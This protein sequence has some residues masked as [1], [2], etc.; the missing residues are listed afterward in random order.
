MIRVLCVEDETELRDTL[1][2]VLEEEGYEVM[3]AANGSEAIQLMAAFRP[4]VIVTD[5]LMPVMNGIEMI[6][7]LRAGGL[8]LARTPVIV[9]SAHAAAT[10]IDTALA[11]GACRYLTKPV[12]FDVLLAAIIDFGAAPDAEATAVC[13]CSF[14][15]PSSPITSGE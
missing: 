13:G 1:L 2:E 12:D 8:P 11:M 14:R 6:R 3:S 7:A 9:V 10:E 4:D 5:W 15:L